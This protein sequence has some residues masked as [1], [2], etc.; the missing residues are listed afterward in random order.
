VQSISSLSDARV[1]DDIIEGVRGL[2]FILRLRPVTYRLNLAKELAITGGQGGP[3][4]PGK[5]DV[6]KIVYSGFLAQEVEQ[7]A[8]DA[9]YDFSGVERPQNAHDLYHL[10]YGDLV[11]PLVK[12]VQEQQQTIEELRQRLS[13]LE[14]MLNATSASK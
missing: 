10:R 13:A 11:T 2:D 6:E 5:H 9:G 14:R 4:Y 12:A 1:K 3:E 7:A 8:K